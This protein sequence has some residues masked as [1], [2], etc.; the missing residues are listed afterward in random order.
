[1]T[2]EDR[3]ELGRSSRAQPDRGRTGTERFQDLRASASRELTSHGTRVDAVALDAKGE[4]AV[5][6]LRS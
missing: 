4:I 2:D 1:M 3:E 5:N 6:I